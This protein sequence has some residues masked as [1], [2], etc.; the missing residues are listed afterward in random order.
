MKN[1]PR[2]VWDV[3]VFVHSVE[4]ETLERDVVIQIAVKRAAALA[5]TGLAPATTGTAT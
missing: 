4:F 1:R 5:A 3:P 2:P